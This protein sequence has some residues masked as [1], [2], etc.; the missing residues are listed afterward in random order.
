MVRPPDW[1][2]STQN[3]T[4]PKATTSPPCSLT[5]E[6]LQPGHSLSSRVSESAPWLGWLRSRWECSRR[7]MSCGTAA[8][9]PDGEIDGDQPL[10]AAS[11]T[12]DD[13]DDERLNTVTRHTPSSWPSSQSQAS[14][15]PASRPAH[16]SS[17]HTS[18][19]S[20]AQTP[21]RGPLSRL[22]SSPTTPSA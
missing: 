18:T 4:H 1:T 14:P 17:P 7:G 13:G 9:M 15:P 22:P 16:A 19:S 6:F 5:T 3:A 8:S 20:S 21:T 10:L 12:R 2:G 11:N